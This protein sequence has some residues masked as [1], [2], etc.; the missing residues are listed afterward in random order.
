MRRDRTGEKA[1]PRWTKHEDG[2]LEEFAKLL[3]PWGAIRDLLPGRTVSACQTR[4]NIKFGGQSNVR[5]ALNKDTRYRQERIADGPAISE[6]AGYYVFKVPEGDPLLQR[7]RHFHGD[8]KIN[9][10]VVVRPQVPTRRTWPQQLATV[11]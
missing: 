1:A 6:A 11:P 2:F 7:L 9:R 3:L 4:W 5:L 8:D 10:N